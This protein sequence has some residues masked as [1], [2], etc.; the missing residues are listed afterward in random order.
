MFSNPKQLLS[1]AILGLLAFETSALEMKP[2]KGPG[3]I[4]FGSATKRSTPEPVNLI[5]ITDPGILTHGRS[6]KREISGNKV[7]D[8]SSETNFFWGAYA[9]DNIYVANFTLSN[10]GDDELILPVENFAQRLKSLHCG[11]PADPNM[12]ME[13]ND[14]DTFNYAKKAWTWVNEKDLNKFTVVTEPD[15]CFKGDNRS[16]FLVHDIKFDDAKRTAYLHAEEKEWHEV[17]HTFHLH[18]GHQY[19]DPTTANAT[20]PHL[21]RDEGRIMNIAT[22][23]NKQLFSYAKNSKQTVGMALAANAKITTHGAIIADFDIERKWWGAPDDVKIEIHP[24]GLK[25]V[26]DLTLKADG[27]L[28]K[29]LDWSLKPEIEIPVAALNIK[30]ILEIGPYVQIGVHLGASKL[31][32]TA[33][34]S[35]GAKASID[36]SATVQVKLRDP[37]DNK[38]SGWKPKFEAIKPRFTAQIGGE[39]RAWTEL[40]ITIKAEAFGMWGYQASIDAQLPYVEANLAAKVDTLGVCG[41]KKTIGIDTST[42]VG[43]NVNLNAGK[44]NQAPDFRKDLYETEWPIF[45]TCLGLGPNNARP[46]SATS[47]K[48]TKASSKKIGT[49]KLPTK[50]ISSTKAAT[51]KTSTL[52]NTV[53]TKLPTVTSALTLLPKPTITRAPTGSI[54]TGSSRITPLPSLPVSKNST[55]VL[56]STKKSSTLVTFSTK[57]MTQNNTMLTKKSTSTSTLTY[58]PL[59]SIIT[60]SSTS[61]VKVF[62][63]HISSGFSVPVSRNTTVVVMTSQTPTPTPSYGS[64][65][66]YGQYG[67]Y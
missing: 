1:T 59:P 2:I 65:G 41:S 44:V 7:F 9:G 33:T 57:Y 6:L 66:S 12:V 3:N 26:L 40:G 58:M 47:A 55:S 67:E 34:F 25:A 31:K 53:P 46:T 10:P 52:K 51:T 17:A 11:S 37:K 4:P 64:Y 8:A 28:G 15:Q 45:S 19:I 24:Q 50:K 16:P 38:I 39:V 30:G 20:H 18:L 29:G 5:P 56:V 32:G 27:T 13:F 14:D 61:V 21:K 63:S 62:T 60:R 23:L 35:T 42:N 43:I 49:T 22:S 36:D 48:A 54:G